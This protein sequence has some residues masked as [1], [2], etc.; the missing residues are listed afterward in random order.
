M[1]ELMTVCNHAATVNINDLRSIDKFGILEKMKKCLKKT[2]EL[3]ENQKRDATL[4]FLTMLAKCKQQATCRSIVG[5]SDCIDKQTK[6]IFLASLDAEKKPKRALER[7]KNAVGELEKQGQDT[8]SLKLVWANLLLRNKKAKEAITILQSC[9][10]LI[11]YPALVSV[12]T[13]LLTQEKQPEEALKVFENA[14]DWWRNSTDDKSA[15]IILT[16]EL[17]KSNLLLAQGQFDM[18]VKCI[19]NLMDKKKLMP[20]LKN[21]RQT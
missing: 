5:T 15:D 13:H 1:L 11:I 7:V 19:E 9:Q 6:S 18:A 14:I 17:E 4:N 2:A 12:L 8:E 16:L 10:K 20:I 3:G 21:Y